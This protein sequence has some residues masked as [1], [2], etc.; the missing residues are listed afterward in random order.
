MLTTFVIEG[1]AT[2]MQMQ[3]TTVL[4]VVAA[5]LIVVHV[6]GRHHKVGCRPFSCGHLHNISY[7]FRR[8]GDPHRCGVESYELDCSSSSKVTIQIN[9]RTYY[10]S[11][12]DYNA[13]VFWVIDANMQDTGCPLLVKDTNTTS[14]CC[15]LPRWDSHSF[16][17]TNYMADNVDLLVPRD[18]ITWAIFVNCSQ[19]LVITN[20]SS[21]KYIPAR[22]LSDHDFFLRLYACCYSLTVFISCHIHRKH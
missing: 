5:A 15:P 12:I 9:T 11:S 7:P 19:E 21:I 20:N 16:F 13:Y 10:V 14:G 8:R 17:W 3:I 4:C 1:R 2:H 18:T 6:Q 22:G